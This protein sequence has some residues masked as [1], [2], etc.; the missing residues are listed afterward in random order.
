MKKPDYELLFILGGVLLLCYLYTMPRSYAAKKAKSAPKT[1]GGK[2]LVNK[3]GRVIKNPKVRLIFWGNWATA[4]P[5]MAQIDTAYRN[6][7]ASTYFNVLLEYGGGKPVYLGYVNNKAAPPKGFKDPDL[8]KAV[9]TM[10]PVNDPNTIYCVLPQ[11]G[12]KA[13]DK[14][15]DAYHDVFNGRGICVYYGKYDMASIMKAMSEEIA[16]SVIDPDD[17]AWH[18]SSDD[19]IGDLCA[20]VFTINGV[21]V[22]GL[23]SNAKGA[24]TTA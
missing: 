18:T 4:T 19:Q 10:Y 20:N 15:G 14:V 7:M 22:E 11:P 23:W 3:G 12:T 6:L 8:T 1:G 16:E 2:K 9:S 13:A 5:T 21:T 24:C 17:A